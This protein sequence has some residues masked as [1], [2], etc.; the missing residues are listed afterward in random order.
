M[1]SADRKTFK[2][3]TGYGGGPCAVTSSHG[4]SMNRSTNRAIEAAPS[5]NGTDA[6]PA[7]MRERA[8]GIFEASSREYA[9]SSQGMPLRYNKAPARAPARVDT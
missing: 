7:I 6:A 2:R 9:G 3:V 8:Y 1:L 5:T 4:E